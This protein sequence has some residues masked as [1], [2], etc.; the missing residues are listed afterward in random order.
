M[1][2][3]PFDIFRPFA[4]RLEINLFSKSDQIQTDEDLKKEL[5]TDA[6]AS[7]WQMHGSTTVIV[8]EPT[9]RIIQADGLMTDQSELTLS[10]R[11][12]DCQTFVVYA[13]DQNVIGLMHVGWRGLIAGMIP[14]FF[15]TLTEEYDIDAEHC[16]IGAGPS[17]CKNC[18]EFTD[19]ITELPGIPEKFI[20]GRYADLQMFA[21]YQLI[22]VGMDPLKFERHPDCTKCNGENWWSF[23]GGDREEVLSGMGNVLLIRIKK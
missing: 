18:A 19:P 22:S 5:Q 7:V 4:D 14:S 3:M 17:L 13:P 21:T 12:A 9:S 16:V 1:M 10:I 6:L 8:R 20:E 2:S 15:R 11:S 23:R